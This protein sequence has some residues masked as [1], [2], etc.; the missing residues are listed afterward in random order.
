M[1][2]IIQGRTLLVELQKMKRRETFK[3]CRLPDAG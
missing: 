3:G 1:L 2:G